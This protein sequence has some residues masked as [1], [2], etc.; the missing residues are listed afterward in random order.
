MQYLLYKLAAVLTA[1]VTNSPI[2]RL[3]TDISKAF[4]LILAMT[5]TAALLTLISIIT[6]VAVAVT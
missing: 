5:G 3:I 6:T 2:S 1:A 4:G